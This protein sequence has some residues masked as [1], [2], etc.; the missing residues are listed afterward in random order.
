MA[1]QQSAVTAKPLR[2]NSQKLSRRK[3]LWLI[4]AIVIA[5][6]LLLGVGLEVNYQIR[7]SRLKSA[8]QQIWNEVVKPVGGM[9]DFSNIN[10]PHIWDICVDNGPCPEA[11]DGWFILV[12]K[13]GE[14]NIQQQILDTLKKN[15][16]DTGTN[17]SVFG[18]TKK[19]LSLDL[20]FYSIG[21]SK[22]P[23]PAPAG[24]VWV[25]LEANAYEVS[26]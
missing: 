9:V 22:P 24:R 23:Y 19:G 2:G 25:E 18:G 1:K 8:N 3:K 14:N 7:V 15:G 6:P 5:I 17:Y 26:Q 16:Y 10:G 13:N 4:L 20:K 11:N 12:D 21:N